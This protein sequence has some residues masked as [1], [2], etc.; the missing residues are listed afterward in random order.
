MAMSLYR[1]GLGMIGTMFAACI[2]GG[3]LLG[4]TIYAWWLKQVPAHFRWIFLVLMCD[5]VFESCMRHRNSLSSATN[6]HARDTLFQL[7]VSGCSVA[8]MWA[9]AQVHTDLIKVIA[10]GAAITLLSLGWAL[11]QPPHRTPPHT[12]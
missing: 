1:K 4:D 9:S 6:Q 11:R 10:P 5:A 7:S 3:L 8:V 12:P 2:V